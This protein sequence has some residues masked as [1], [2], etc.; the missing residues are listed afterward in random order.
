MKKVIKKG[1]EIILVVFPSFVFA[2]REV[3]R[4]IDSSNF[5]TLFRSLTKVLNSWVLGILVLFALVNFIY[6][7]T[8]Y[9]AEEGD[10]GD[11]KEK[12]MKIFWNIIALF[13]I[14]S[15]W[16]IVFTISNTFGLQLGGQLEGWGD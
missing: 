12:K 1:I 14:L 11:K 4:T 13:I 8:V 3:P 6:S 16:A 5:S 10:S 9:I 7:V 2:Q 15:I